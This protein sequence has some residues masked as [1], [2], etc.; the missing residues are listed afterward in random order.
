MDFYKI[1]AVRNGHG[2]IE[3]GPS[4]RILKSK[5]LMIKGGKFYAFWD[6]ANSI[7]CTDMYRL[8]ECI[9]NDIQKFLEDKPEFKHEKVNYMRTY[10]SQAAKEF[11]QYV[12]LLPDNWH[13][14]DDTVTF[15]SEKIGREDYKSRR[16]PY[17]PQKGDIS[18][19]EEL[20]NV[21]YFPEEREKIEWAIGSILCGE[22]KDIQKFMVLYGN[23]GTGKSTIMNMIDHMFPGYVTTFDSK[24]LGS[25]NSSFSL[26]PFENNP[27]V[28]IQHDGD[29]SRIEDNT[30]INSVVSHEMIN[31]NAKYKNIYA[32][33]LNCFLFVGT[34]KPVKITDA[35]SGIIRRLIDVH[36]TGETVEQSRYEELCDIIAFETSAIAYHCMQVYK[37][38]G[39]RYYSGYRPL[40]M[41]YKTDP[42]FN[43]VDSYY[44]TFKNQN[45]TTLKQ[46]YTLYK[47]WVD[48]GGSD[49]KMTTYKFR[50]AL[51][52]YFE[53][54]HNRTK[55]ATGNDIQD[56]YNNFKVD[57][58]KDRMRVIERHAVDKIR[59]TIIPS[60]LDDVLANMKAQYATRDGKP[61]QAWESVR[62]TLKDLDT[63]Q[64]HYVLMPENYIV[65]DFDLKDENG[66]KSTKLN[67]E[68]AAKFPPTYTEL[69]RSGGVHLHYIYDGDIDLL[70]NIYAENIEIKK[71][72]G[73]ASLRRK[74]T[75][76]NDVPIAHIRDGLPLKGEK[77]VD[78]K[79]I[80]D[81]KHLRNIIAKN[82]AKQ[83]SPNTKP[84]IDYIYNALQQAYESGMHY[85]VS[86][87]R[88]AIVTFAMDSTN[89]SDA[90]LKLVAKM[91]FQSEE[92]TEDLDWDKIGLSINGVSDM[93]T[94]EDE[95]VFFDCEV[96]PNLFLI[97]WKKIGEGK[98]IH[99][100]I[101]PSPA[102]VESLMQQPLVGFNCRRY[103]NH[104]LYARMMG[105][106]N[107][108]LYQLSRR[109]IDAGKKGPKDVF[110]KEA[111]NISYTDIYDY[112]ATK[113][114]LK[115][116][117][118]QLGI[119][120]EEL[121]LPWDQ[122]VPE[123]LWDKVAHYCDNDVIAT[124]AVWNAT[125]GDWAARK[126][127]AKIAGMTP[128]STTNSL[129]TRIIF[130]KDSREEVQKELVY[131]DL[132]KEFP[133]YKFE[134]GKSTYKGIETG[135]GGY[136]YASPGV[137]GHVKV[138]DV[139]SM[140]PHS[141][142]ALNLFGKYTQ[143]FKE[144]LEARVAAKHNDIEKLETLLDGL[145]LEYVGD[146]ATRKALVQA[147]KIAINSVYGLTCASFDHLFKDPRNVDN[148]VAKRGAL[149]MINLKE[150][151]E[152]LGYTVVHIKTDS[153]K[154]ENPDER[155][156]NFINEYGKKYGYEFEVEDEFDRVC[157]INDAEFIAYDMNENKWY[158]KGDRFKTPYT[159]KT[160]FTH[161]PITFDDLC[162]TC[163]VTSEI[164][165]DF[166]EKKPS[167]I[168][169]E[170][171]LDDILKVRKYLSGNTLAAPSNKKI[172]MYK[173]VTDNQIELIKRRIAD[174][175]DYKFVGRVGR[176]V[177]VVEGCGGGLL[178][179]KNG[180]KFD[181]VQGT[182]GYRW[183]E[184]EKVKGT[185]TESYIDQSYWLNIAS[186]VKD[187][188]I[189][190]LNKNIGHSCYNS[191]EEFLDAEALPF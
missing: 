82:L 123:E 178:V 109:I 42:F 29:L 3:I 83:I 96:F 140:H 76:C 60:L 183:L 130:G 54:Y 122:P 127:L 115:K 24:A 95:I 9:D 138:F 150:E 187:V 184:A 163:A 62:T 26:E 157:L 165:L 135:E 181:A 65:I 2:R 143:R 58:F 19:Y 146:D 56:F 71:F 91:K 31:I 38:L 180:D 25:G 59:L 22:S 141:L 92:P 133:G 106:S 154:V 13:S 182:K 34:N 55:D 6:D 18:A 116:W 40:D 124:E 100:M 11:E 17:D 97:N 23:A 168:D 52:D 30:K 120:H 73:N 151:V 90:C 107:E 177:P 28:G 142:I 105:Y 161:E 176:F 77:M 164:D 119:H 20:V 104:M 36:P 144:I 45:S 5:D 174:C 72:K 14:L 128:N 166:N 149:F 126:I 118:I 159:F 70:G 167:S 175:H 160:L 53:E 1:E 136:V 191:I 189:E 37:S 113:Q 86:D 79:G 139:V 170:K 169:M 64:L 8:Y 108:Q 147:L 158:P 63:S 117:E 185:D 57:L 4:L 85:D 132:S 188:M 84:S 94:I 7:W 173:D 99:R 190:T 68:A 67:L 112:A 16:L 148:I 35:K 27:L 125:Q 103:D 49:F 186:D 87:M 10:K 171:E 69:S 110:F 162:L 152:K 78:F 66:K 12:R 121:G 15:L 137:Y 111:F 101:N 50:E 43:F 46:A 89:Q 21:L 172:E 156:T 131:T 80:A 48:N 32:M 145:L 134:N 47:E 75:K 98:R 93:S 179:R 41:M 44:L 51:K 33:R 153:I 155:I 39:K 102:E 129:T 61:Q 74:L 114:S 81:E 88:Q